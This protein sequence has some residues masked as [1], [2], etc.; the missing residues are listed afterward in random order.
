MLIPNLEALAAIRHASRRNYCPFGADVWKLLPVT[1]GR[2]R[3]K[4][5]HRIV[6]VDGIG[7][8]IP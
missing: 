3:I 4:A 8:F 7:V 2:V 6:A 1:V 5:V